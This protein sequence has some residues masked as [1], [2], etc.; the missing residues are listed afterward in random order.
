MASGGCTVAGD[1]TWPLRKPGD[2]RPNAGY[3]TLAACDRMVGFVP[4]GRT[5]IRVNRAGCAVLRRVS[6]HYGESVP[7]VWTPGTAVD[8]T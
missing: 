8:E 6:D 4:S 5:A 7:A 1:S 2:V 3:V